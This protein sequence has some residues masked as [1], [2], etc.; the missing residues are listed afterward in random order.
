LVHN[1]I[2]LHHSAVQSF[3]LILAAVALVLKQMLLG[4]T[5]C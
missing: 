4:G 1:I 2:A 5:L 3:G